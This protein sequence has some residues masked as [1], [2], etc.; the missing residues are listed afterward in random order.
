MDL[1]QVQVTTVDTELLKVVWSNTLTDFLPYFLDRKTVLEE[2]EK[3]REKL[4]SFINSVNLHGIENSCTEYK[5]LAI[6]GRRLYDFIFLPEIDTIQWANKV[7]EWLK[8]FKRPIKIHFTVD[9]RIQIPWGLVYESDPNEIEINSLKDAKQSDSNFW[10]DKY[11]LTAIYRKIM[12]LSDEETVL[13]NDTQLFPT[14]NKSVF[15]NNISKL[16]HP[17]KECLESIVNKFTTSKNPIFTSVDFWS[18]CEKKKKTPLFFYFC[19]HARENNL[20]L[21]V[22]D[23]IS[24]NDLK[25]KFNSILTENDV[26]LLFV[27]GCSTAVGHKKG[28]FIEASSQKGLYGFI[29]SETKIPDHFAFRFGIDFLSHFFYSGMTI[30]EL[31]QLLRKKH[32]PISLAYGVYCYPMLKIGKKPIMDQYLST[33]ENNLSHERLGSDEL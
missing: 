11:A 14:F 21:G 7:K 1:I 17:E 33:I 18:Q 15:D 16:I 23:M 26:A 24:V 3:V 13:P 5:D 31:M 22:T 29:G 9:Q 12:P 32:W 8:T 2:S 4:Y 30:C 10:C 28:G 25:L 20:E 6:A 27:N 19:C